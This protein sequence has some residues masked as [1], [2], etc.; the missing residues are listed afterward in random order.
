MNAKVATA[1]CSGI[2]CKRKA[3][4]EI[5]IDHFTF[6]IKVLSHHCDTPLFSFIIAHP[7]CRIRVNLVLQKTPYMT[8]KF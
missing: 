5:L 2:P 6:L 1:I 4:N 8:K 7:K 3:M